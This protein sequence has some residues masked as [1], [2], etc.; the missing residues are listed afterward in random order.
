MKKMIFTAL[1]TM[2][3]VT[4]I[5]GD[6][7]GGSIQCASASGRTQV[8]VNAGIDNPY[9]SG[10]LSAVLTIDGKSLSMGEENKV[11]SE[12]ST[13]FGVASFNEKKYTGV[14]TE[15]VPDIA[16][17]THD[18]FSLNSVAGS[19][20]KESKFTYSFT[21]LLKAVDPRSDSKNKKATMTPE[22]TVRCLLDLGI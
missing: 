4:A 15:I 21:A 1:V 10:P 9:G 8:Q 14:I 7:Y 19:M 5:A 3:S 6:N 16:T 18:V 20:K 11:L 13:V 17:Y 22:I 12:K 2:M